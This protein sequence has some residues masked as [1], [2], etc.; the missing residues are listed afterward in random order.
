MHMW[1]HPRRIWCL[2]FRQYVERLVDL[3]ELWLDIFGYLLHAFF[4][5][6]SG[7]IRMV[8]TFE[9]AVRG[10]RHGYV[11]FVAILA[12]LSSIVLWESMV[13]IWMWN[14]WLGNYSMRSM[15]Q[16]ESQEPGFELVVFYVFVRYSIYW[17]HQYPFCS[18]GFVVSVVILY[19]LLKDRVLI[20]FGLFWKV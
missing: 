8:T 17:C 16:L 19:D 12:M 2:A 11:S 1:H 10:S 18:I 5:D 15:R 13:W 20:Y 7:S 14:L 3:W 6:V 4:L 9:T